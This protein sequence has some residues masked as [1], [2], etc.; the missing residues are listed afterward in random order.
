MAISRYRRIKNATHRG[1]LVKGHASV[2][3]TIRTLVNRGQLR[4]QR[5]VLSQGQRLDT[6]STNVYGDPKYW[7]V[8]AAAS[9]IGW[10]CQCPPGTVL[11][12]PDLGAVLEIVG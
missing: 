1:K 5:F 4:F 7:W 8:I 6:V 11:I 12:V 9:G 2:S 3:Y 10:Q